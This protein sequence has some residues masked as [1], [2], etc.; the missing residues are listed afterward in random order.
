MDPGRTWKRGGYSRCSVLTQSATSSQRLSMV[1]AEHQAFH[2]HSCGSGYFSFLQNTD[3]LEKTIRFKRQIKL[4]LHTNQKQCQIVKSFKTCMQRWQ[5]PVSLWLWEFEW[6]H[7]VLIASSQ[8]KT[9]LVKID[10]VGFNTQS[11]IRCMEM[12]LLIKGMLLKKVDYCSQW[13]SRKHIK[14]WWPITVQKPMNPVLETD[15]KL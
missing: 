10:L 9:T 3:N 12:E 6:H 14:R 13:G 7:W 8:L 2:R 1:R 15:G 4:H 11:Q 5:T